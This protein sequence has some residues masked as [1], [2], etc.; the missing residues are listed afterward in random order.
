MKIDDLKP[1]PFESTHMTP[2]RAFLICE[3][4]ALRRRDAGGGKVADQIASM[5]AE[6]AEARREK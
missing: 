4:I 2:K 5:I 6:V 1:S 3:I